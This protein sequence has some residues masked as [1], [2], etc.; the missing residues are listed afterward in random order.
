[1]SHD[2]ALIEVV[3]EEIYVAE[4][5]KIAEFKDNFDEYRSIQLRKALAP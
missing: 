1:M 4:D 5:G 3:A 2:Q